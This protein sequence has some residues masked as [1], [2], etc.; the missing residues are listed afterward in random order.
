MYKGMQ[1]DVSLDVTPKDDYRFALNA[2][3]ES[4]YGEVDGIVNENSNELCINALGIMLGSI[5]INNKIVIFHILFGISTI[6][7]FNPETCTTQQLLASQVGSLNFNMNYPISGTHKIL[8][9][10]DETI[11]YWVDGLNPVRYLNLSKIDEL[12]DIEGLNL[13]VCSKGLNLIVEGVIDNGGNLE[14]GVYQF[15]ISYVNG[16]YSYISNPIS[17]YKD[18][19]SN[20]FKNID[21]D[22]AGTH[23]TKAVQLTINNIDFT[24]NEEFKIVVIKTINNIV[25]VYEL[26]SQQTSGISSTYT[27]TGFEE[28]AAVALNSVTVPTA[29]F[30]TAWLIAQHQDRL[31]LANLKQTRNIDYQLFANQIETT[32]F[33]N[34]LKIDKGYKNPTIAMNNKSFMAD[35]VYSIGIVWEFCDGS[36][37]PAFHIPGPDKLSVQNCAVQF[38]IVSEFVGLEVNAY[39]PVPTDYGNIEDLVPENDANNFLGCPA[40]VWKIFNTACI[41]G[42]PEVESIID[43]DECGNVV[44]VSLGNWHVGRLAYWEDCE[45]YP[46]IERCDGTSMFGD[47]TGTPVRYHRMPSRRLEP[48]FSSNEL[49]HVEDPENLGADYKPYDDLYVYPIGL[50]FSN[51]IPPPDAEVQVKRYHIVYV[52]RTE[53]NKSV[54]AK[55]LTHKCVT[56]TDFIGGGAVQDYPKHAVNSNA[57]PIFTGGAMP[58][59]SGEKSSNYKFHSPNTSISNYYSSKFNNPSLNVTYA[60]SDYQHHG[61]GRVY[62]YEEAQQWVHRE[63]INLDRHQ[64]VARLTNRKVDFTSYVNANSIT[65]TSTVPLNNIGGESSVVFHLKKEDNASLHVSD[66]FYFDINCAFD[67]LYRYE[68]QSLISYDENSTNEIL[69]NKSHYVALKNYRCSQYGSLLGQQYISTGYYNNLILNIST[70]EYEPAYANFKVYGDSFI[71]YWSYRR[72][73]LTFQILLESTF[74][75]LYDN[76]EPMATLIHSVFESDINVDLRHEG[77]IGNGEIYYPSL[78]RGVWVLDSSIPNGGEPQASYLQQFRY[79]DD[80]DEYVGLGIDNYYNYNIDYSKVND[81]RLFLGMGLNYKTCACNNQL[82]N[83]IAV[84]EEDNLETKEDGWLVF[85]YNNYLNIPRFTGQ[86]NNIFTIANNF[87]AHTENNLWRVYTTEDQLLTNTQNLYIGSGSIFGQTPKYLYAADEGA[88]GLQQN[89]GTLLNQ[90]GYFFIDNKG[91]MVYSFDGEKVKPLN[92]GMLNWQKEMLPYEMKVANNY[93]NPE[94]IGWHMGFDHRHSRLLITFKDYKPLQPV[95]ITD[96]KYY[97]TGIGTE[98]FPLDDTWFCNTSFTLSYSYLTERFVSFHSY[99]PEMYIQTRKDLFSVDVQNVAGFPYPLG[100]LWK[101]NKPNDY[102]TFY[103]NYRPHKLELVDTWD[104]IKTWLNVMYQQYAYEYNALYGSEVLVLNTFDSAVLWNTRQ[105]SGGL[106]LVAKTEEL[107]NYME[108]AIDDN[109]TYVNNKEGLWYFNQFTDAVVDYTIPHN[110]QDCLAVVNQAPNPI[111][112]GTKEYY[113]ISDFRD[114]FIVYRLTKYKLADRYKRYVT[115]Q[116]ASNAVKSNR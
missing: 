67:P 53:S 36:Y 107:D 98:V 19:F 63:N 96:F 116:L 105:N 27:Y 24:H 34:K 68:D 4:R 40:P 49:S 25:T 92:V 23:T 5:H 30:L 37:S 109:V 101:H 54:I 7:M 60:A 99:I 42:K 15:A 61:K 56:S 87:F 70:N 104:S 14:S 51:V 111:V 88:S 35:E 113:N 55:G 85:R 89:R 97:L 47:L 110:T 45:L 77:N 90:Y 11:I 93:T 1:M 71:N 8:D 80:A 64:T 13:F 12:V 18:N 103:G 74:L 44:D 20:D 91:G 83:T 106:V 26:P 69:C 82:K 3:V 29:T 112:L 31:M 79:D 2:V 50:E 32:W 62:G 52:K 38:P 115:K 73:D 58:T 65:T 86:L 33:T 94:G 28:A 9:Y 39:E 102:Q 41:T 16:N 76:V 81:T 48:H 114:N 72:T 66:F 84:S 22:P 78:G 17:V 10:C 100:S 75:D 46:Q 21:G 6:S 108:N 57:A 95:T 59:G 43:I